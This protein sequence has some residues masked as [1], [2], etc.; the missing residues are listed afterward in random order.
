MKWFRHDSDAHNNLKFQEVWDK[1]KLMGYGLFWLCCEL[2][3]SHSNSKR[4]RFLLKK[5]KNWL[6]YLKKVCGVSEGTLQKML[7]D[8]AEIN[9]ISKKQ[10]QKGTLSIPKMKERLDEYTE[11]VVKGW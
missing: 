4:P 1:W 6:K 9:L 10:L 3:A 5:D 11:S 7:D 2:V 8:F